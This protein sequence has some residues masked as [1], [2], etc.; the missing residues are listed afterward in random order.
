MR[1]LL[2]IF[3][4]FLA[5]YQKNIHSVLLLESCNLE[6]MNELVESHPEVCRIDD[7]VGHG[8]GSLCQLDNGYKFILTAAH[9]C[10]YDPNEVY[11]SYTKKQYKIK[12]IISFKKYD[13][14]FP[15]DK[16]FFDVG[17]IFLEEYPDDI[18][19]IKITSID[20]SDI[21]ESI[22]EIFGFGRWG[23]YNDSG[24]GKYIKDDWSIFRA[25]QLKI[26]I[27]KIIGGYSRSNGK[28]KSCNDDLKYLSFNKLFDGSLL[29]LDA[30]CSPGDSGGPVMKD[31]EIVGIMVSSIP[32]LMEFPESVLF[33]ALH[34]GWI[35]NI[36]V[37][38]DTVLSSY[39]KF[40]YCFR[41]IAQKTFQLP[42][43]SVRLGQKICVITPA[44]KKWI[45]KEVALNNNFN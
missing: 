41:K 23:Y 2:T 4:F 37:K 21:D 6:K 36:L 28:H 17:I 18:E 38:I 22:V 15:C 5:I 34:D 29:E 31:N 27:N 20:L 19:A 40:Q 26:K 16:G 12:K 9:V 35:K 14:N 33:N 42:D 44:I 11:F 32:D 43:F 25:G 10:K 8:T 7:K 24:R 45:E 3:L 30:A 1:N 39:Q 13:T